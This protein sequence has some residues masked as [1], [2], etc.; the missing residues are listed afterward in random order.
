MQETFPLLGLTGYSYGLCIALGAALA[1]GLLG[2]QSRAWGLPR[3]TALLLGALGIPLG[4]FFA[5]LLFCLFHLS[6]FLQTYENPL[7]MLRFF[8]GG[9]SM[10][11]LLMGLAL[12]ALAASRLLNIRLGQALDALAAPLALLIAFCRAAERFTAL[13][14]GKVVEENA[15]TSAAPWLF[16]TET[17]GIATEYRMA[18]YRYEAAAALLLCVILLFVGRRARRGK[19]TLAGDVALVFFSLYGASQMVLESLRDDGHLMI[20]FLRIAQ[21]AAFLMPVLAC[22]V[23][24]GRYVRLRGKADGRV[25]FSWLLVLLCLAGAVLT[26]FSLDGRLTWGNP[27][28]LRDYGILTALALLLLWAPLSLFH[29]LRRR[30]YAQG[31]ILAPVDA[32]KEARRS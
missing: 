16:V 1:L 20:T 30:I 6:G 3:G 5:R 26:E 10:T 31:V 9:F 8:D 27:S 23:F 25:V 28:P 14:V 11:G 7:L 13:G 22:A 24:A 2:A 12:A 18:V 4:L 19:D 17:A 21:V 29:T 15:L 32:E